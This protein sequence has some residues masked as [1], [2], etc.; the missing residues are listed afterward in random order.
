MT[1]SVE[2]CKKA[3]GEDLAILKL[4]ADASECSVF[5][6]CVQFLNMVF[7]F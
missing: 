6:H 7:K 3:L 4:K 5:E 2:Q 1:I